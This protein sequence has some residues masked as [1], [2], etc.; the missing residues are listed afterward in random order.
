MKSMTGYGRGTHAVGE[1]EA[2]VQTSSVNRKSLEVSVSMPRAWQWL[3]PEIGKQVRAVAQRG[4]IQV[5]VECVAANGPEIA[6]IDEETIDAIDLGLP[7]AS[8]DQLQ[9]SSV[10]HSAQIIT[11]IFAGNPSPYA[12][13]VILTAAG[14]P[15]IADACDDFASG[16]ELARSTIAQGHAKTTLDRLIEVSQG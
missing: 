9:A 8:L 12:D 11:D 16:I 6:S 4:R 1:W 10:E 3:E 13:M 2:T 5:A 7:R 15:L 14:A